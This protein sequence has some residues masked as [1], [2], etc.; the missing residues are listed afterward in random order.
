MLTLRVAIENCTDKER[1]ESLLALLKRDQTGINVLGTIGHHEEDLDNTLGDRYQGMVNIEGKATRGTYCMR[2]EAFHKTVQL[3]RILLWLSRGSLPALTES[4]CR[5]RL[6]AHVGGGSV[7][8]TRF[9]TSND[10]LADTTVLL[11]TDH[12]S[13]HLL[14]SEG[15]DET[16]TSMGAVDFGGGTC[17]RFRIPRLGACEF[18]L[19]KA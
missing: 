18:A 10:L 9:N 17:Q 6:S 19:L 15:V 14:T 7:A 4:Y 11:R 5:A 2:D 12:A 16:I 13:A 8:A 1:F 3:K